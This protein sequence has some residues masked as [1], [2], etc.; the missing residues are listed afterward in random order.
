MTAPIAEG[1]VGHNSGT[2]K[3]SFIAEITAWAL[4]RRDRLGQA[5]NRKE[6]GELDSTQRIIAQRHSLLD[7]YAEMYRANPRL[8]IL[9]GLVLFV[10]FF[11]DNNN[12]CCTYAMKRI[13]E[14]FGRSEKAVREAMARGVKQG[15]IFRDRLPNDVYSYW[16]V[17]NRV[18]VDPQASSH[19]FVDARSPI[20]RAR[21]RPKTPEN[22]RTTSCGSFEE[23]PETTARRPPELPHDVPPYIPYRDSLD[24]KKDGGA[25]ASD[26]SCPDKLNE[27]SPQRTIRAR[28][29]QKDRFCT[30]VS[31]WGTKPGSPNFIIADRQVAVDNLDNGLVRHANRDPDMVLLGIDLALTDMEARRHDEVATGDHRGRIGLGPCASFFSKTLNTKINEL[32][33]AAVCLEASARAEMTVQQA[34]LQKRLNGVEK[35]G[36]SPRR[37]QKASLDDLAAYALGAPSEQGV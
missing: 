29:D 23:R 15:L 35:G 16:P 13:G 37:G 7:N 5:M 31:T 1:G 36:G 8:D 10:T 4:N 34:D 22:Y 12:G 21:H 32:L 25:E 24:D 2:R 26:D 14:F 19:W 28:A 17:V 6:L 27:T 33:L 11:S 18:L 3:I 20:P 30:L 9:P